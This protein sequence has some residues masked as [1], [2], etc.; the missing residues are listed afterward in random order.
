MFFEHLADADDAALQRL[1][2]SLKTALP[3]RI[4]IIGL[5]SA[6][7]HFPFSNTNFPLNIEPSTSIFTDISTE[8]R[9]PKD[10]LEE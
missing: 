1:V 10:K 4:A 6:V 8:L 5:N 9:R 3:I 7:R 2:I